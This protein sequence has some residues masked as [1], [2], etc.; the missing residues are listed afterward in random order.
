[1]SRTRGGGTRNWTHFVA[2]ISWPKLYCSRWHEQRFWHFRGLKRVVKGPYGTPWGPLIFSEF[3][4]YCCLSQY[5][6]NIRKARFTKHPV[7]KYVK[8]KKF[9]QMRYIFVE[10]ESK[11]YSIL[12]FYV[13]TFI[14]C[15]FVSPPPLFFLSSSHYPSCFCCGCE[16][17][18]GNLDLS[19]QIGF[20][21]PPPPILLMLT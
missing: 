19:I 1:M 7:C 17:K 5:K 11:A 10:C 13:T 18:L 20:L 4:L 9:L 2:K 3:S 15:F 16:Y 6:H 21:V 14:I 8:Q 12:F